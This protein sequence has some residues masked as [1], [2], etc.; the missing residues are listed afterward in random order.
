MHQVG[1][2]KKTGIPKPYLHVPSRATTH[3]DPNPLITKHLQN[4]R[5]PYANE[6]LEITLQ[7]GSAN[8]VKTS[9]N[10][11]VSRFEFWAENP[12]APEE[13]NCAGK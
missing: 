7:T 12:C 3:L 1:I 2:G 5:V 9:R 11:A 10:A 6:C 4:N 13:F 8:S